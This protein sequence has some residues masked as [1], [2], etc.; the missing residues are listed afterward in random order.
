M[1]SPFNGRGWESFGE[2]PLLQGR[3]GVGSVRGVQSND[4]YSLAKHY[5][6]NDQETKRGSVDEQVDERTL[7]E[8]YVRPWEIL[9]EEEEP[10]AIMCA[11]PRVNG[12]KACNNEHLLSDILKGRLGFEGFVSSDYNA[13]TGV[14]SFLAG[15]DVCGPAG[16]PF[17]GPELKA[18]VEGGST[19]DEPLQRHGAPSPSKLLRR[20]ALRQPATGRVHRRAESGDSGHR[21]R[22]QR[23]DLTPGRARG[24]RAVEERPAR[25]ASRR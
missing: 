13:C 22:S 12:T 20:R 14:E 23:T 10:G 24:Q 7:N 9:V 16:G 1:R 4:I 18:L 2:D 17:N 21:P 5:T 8:L 19:S 3:M 6:L 25:A 11:F 15:A